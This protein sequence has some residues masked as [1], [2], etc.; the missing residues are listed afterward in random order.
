MQDE[1]RTSL[2]TF[3]LVVPISGVLDV[4]YAD[5]PPIITDGIEEALERL[6]QQEQMPLAIVQAQYK[7]DPDYAVD[8]PGHHYLHVIA[9]EIIAA[10][11]RDLSPGRVIRQL[12][13]DIKDLLN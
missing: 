12:P 7:T 10:D 8:A 1:Q 6:G 3:E 4:P 9:S 5:W 2:K 13:D 11:E